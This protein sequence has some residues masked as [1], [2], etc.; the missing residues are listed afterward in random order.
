MMHMVLP[1]VAL[2]Y[3]FVNFIDVLGSLIYMAYL[4][5]YYDRAPKNDESERLY[6]P[7]NGPKSIRMLINLS[8]A[9]LPVIFFIIWCILLSAHVNSK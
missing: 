7:V 9:V 3:T 6:P 2:L 4:K 8:P 1:I 5:K